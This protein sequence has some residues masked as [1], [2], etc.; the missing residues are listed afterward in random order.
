MP[1]PRDRRRT[2][3]VH[4]APRRRRRGNIVINADR[5]QVFRMPTDPASVRLVVQVTGQ[6]KRRL[7][8]LKKRMRKAGIETGGDFARLVFLQGLAT[9]EARHPQPVGLPEEEDAA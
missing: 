6:Q 8:S 9:L 5:P 1:R 3:P 7:A 4:G 2:D